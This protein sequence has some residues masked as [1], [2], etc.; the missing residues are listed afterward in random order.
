MYGNQTEKGKVMKNFRPLTTV[1]LAAFLFSL[2][3]PQMA[4]AAT[5]S[6]GRSFTVPQLLIFLLVLGWYLLNHFR[7]KVIALLKKNRQKE[8]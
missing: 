5:S 3:F 1:L 7:P 8:K 6:E 2:A 4:H